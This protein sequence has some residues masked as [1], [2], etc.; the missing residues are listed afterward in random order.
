MNLPKPRHCEWRI[1][2]WGSC[3][4]DAYEE[5]EH[6]T[7][8]CNYHADRYV[9]RGGKLVSDDVQKDGTQ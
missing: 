7:V 6:G 9:E 5:T 3:D 1:S 8:L 2:E 4:A